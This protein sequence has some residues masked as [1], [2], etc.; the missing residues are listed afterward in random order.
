MS[1]AAP[2]ARPTVSA[3]SNTAEVVAPFIGGLEGLMK[4]FEKT[5]RKAFD[6]R[7]RAITFTA[8]PKEGGSTEP[9]TVHENEIFQNIRSALRRWRWNFRCLCIKADR[10]GKG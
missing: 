9:G 6:L 3:P 8:R 5:S 10:K 2:I 7:R 4:N 1:V